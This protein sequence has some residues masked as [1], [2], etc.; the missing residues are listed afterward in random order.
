[1]SDGRDVFP[2][3]EGMSRGRED[4]PG[5]TSTART[6]ADFDRRARYLAKAASLGQVVMEDA[7]ER[8][9]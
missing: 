6:D 4:V 9:I 3:G 8:D 7:I 2:G 5:D 1:M